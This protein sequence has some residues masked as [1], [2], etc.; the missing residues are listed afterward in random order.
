M[1][2]QQSPLE[3]PLR[4]PDIGMGHVSFGELTPLPGVYDAHEAQAFVP[5]FAQESQPDSGLNPQPFVAVAALGVGAYVM[6]RRR[7]NKKNA[8]ATAATEA[9]G[10]ST[11]RHHW[12]PPNPDTVN[13]PRKP[14]ELKPLPNEDPTMG[15]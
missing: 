15:F 1:T 2:N 7:A 5:V 4:T 9:A 14:V 3:L 6:H 10:Q 13:Q 12:A 11:P 8:T